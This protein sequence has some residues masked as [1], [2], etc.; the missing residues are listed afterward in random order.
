MYGEECWKM[1]PA[2]RAMRHSC[3]NGC[4]QGGKMNKTDASGEGEITAK[5]F[6]EIHSVEKQR[7]GIDRC[8]ESIGLS[9][10]GGGIRSASFGLGVIQGLLEH[11]IM[12][13]VDYLSTVSGGGYIGASLTWYRHLHPG[14]T[15]YFDASNPFGQKGEGVRS[16]LQ[17]GWNATN[18]NNFLSY[19]RQHGNYLC[20]G[21]LLNFTSVIGAVLRNLLISFMIYFMLLVFAM[22]VWMLATNV[23]AKKT[24]SIPNLK[25]VVVSLQKAIA[26]P[27]KPSSS[28]TGQP[29]PDN[30]SKGAIET[31]WMSH[32]FFQVNLA[33]AS[34][35]LLAFIVYGFIFSV[36]TFRAPV[37][38]AEMSS[39]SY[40]DRSRFQWISGIL[41]YGFTVFLLL[42]SVPVFNDLFSNWR[43]LLGAGIVG[44]ISGLWAALSKFRKFLGGKSLFEK[45]PWIGDRLFE[46]GAFIFLFAMLVFSYNLCLTF[47]V[48]GT[49]NDP[50]Y[51]N[52]LIFPVLIAIAAFFFGYFVDINYASPGRMYRDRLMEAFLPDDKS[53]ETNKWDLAWQA[54][55][56]L[57][58]DMCKENGSENKLRK[59]FHLINANV[60]LTNSKEEK[61]RRRGGD[62]FL[63]SPL[64]CGSD[65]TGYVETNRFMKNKNREN[66]G[67]TL[68]TAMAISG[69]AANPH[70]AVA[71]EGPTRGALLSML[72]TIFNLRL[73]SWVSNPGKGAQRE[74]MNYLMPGICSLLNI[75]Y[76]ENR[77]CLELT[78][79]GH[80]ENLGLYELVRRR[81]GIIIVSDAGVDK[82][83]K[84][85][86]LANAIEK[87][88]TD[89]GVSIRFE[90]EDSVLGKLLPGAAA[91][92]KLTVLQKLAEQGYIRGKVKYPKTDNSSAF[93]G[94]I[95]LLKTT[96][97]KDLPADLYS[98]RARHN[99]FPDQPTSD[100]F[101]DEKQFE[102]YREL[103]YRL[104]D[105][106]CIENRKL[107]R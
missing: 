46:I 98:Y 19:I 42:A 32:T 82:D 20:P 47:G 74:K 23:T 51:L 95:L 39:S 49:K 96:I 44:G 53:V 58:E 91:S 87:V 90:P 77:S 64:F 29:A 31:K 6:D 57:L 7:L 76:E 33:I 67:I 28:D 35:F 12:Q 3:R 54:N 104:A 24:P 10:S 102:A 73:G 79:G 13:K 60:I 27:E 99:D 69:A 81:V 105:S 92:G 72:M 22:S 38:D 1:V 16:S 65:A 52:G 37:K 80:F 45:A 75:G 2:N 15:G 4:D 89:F 25:A 78:D 14:S 11:G 106:M 36:M 18:G 68:A 94:T 86:D 34:I 50:L 30:Q 84:F 63:L 21:R 97:T 85:G 71:G 8:E 43:K 17:T 88:R 9:L 26:R 61:F 107:F 101:F 59:P 103:G 41:L 48:P 93:N 56:A 100:Q 66:G 70:T 40:T 5:S 55:T 62:S 83:F